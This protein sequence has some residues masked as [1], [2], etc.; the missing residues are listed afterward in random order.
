MTTVVDEVAVL[1]SDS[2]EGFQYLSVEPTRRILCT[3][4]C[5]EAVNERPRSRLG[6][7]PSKW[8]VEEVGVGVETLLKRN[9]TQVREQLQVIL[10]LCLAG[11]VESLESAQDKVV[12]ISVDTKIASGGRSVAFILV[13]RA[14]DTLRLTK[15]VEW[16]AHA[17][18]RSTNRPAVKVAVEYRT[19]DAEERR[20][21]D[22]DAENYDGWLMTVGVDQLS[23]YLPFPVLSMN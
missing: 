17:V 4:V 9:M 1:S 7:H 13:V 8:C 11:I 15:E 10:I 14:R 16:D 19:V 12:V 21:I 5:H 18:V 6:D 22:A 20:K 2:K 23:Y 3:L